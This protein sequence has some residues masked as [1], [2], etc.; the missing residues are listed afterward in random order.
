M[1]RR[2]AFTIIALAAAFIVTFNLISGG[3]ALRSS[4]PA[5]PDV[6]I[7]LDGLREDDYVLLATDPTDLAGPIAAWYGTT[8]TELTKLYAAN[9]GNYLYLYVDLPTYSKGGSSGEIGVAIDTSGDVSNSGGSA[10]PWLNEI[11]FAYTSTQ[12]QVGGTPV[13]STNTILPDFMIRGN[14][15]GLSGNPPDDNNGWTEL[16]TWSSAGAGGWSGA[17]TNWGGIPT[18]GQIGTY[19]AYSDNRGVEFK[20]P[21]AAL[22]L[23]PGESV[24]LEFFTTQ[25]GSASVKGAFDTL[26]SDDQSTG[27]DDA[28]VQKRLATYVI[29]GASPTETPTATNTPQNTLTPTPGPLLT[30]TPTATPNGVGPCAGTTAGDGNITTAEVYHNSTN[31]TYREPQGSITITGTATLRLRT[32]QNDVQQVK[33][34]VWKT[35]DP[36]GSPSNIYNAVVAGYDPSGPYEYW[37]YDVPGPGTTVDQWYQ[38][39]ITDGA[40]T[41]YY[42][43]LQGASNT[44]PGAW[45]ESLLD[46]SWKLG[47]QPAPTQDYAVPS[48]LKDAIIYQIFPDRFRD[49]NSANNAPPYT[50]NVTI[51]GP[52]TCAGYPH[53]HNSDPDCVVDGRAWNDSLL[54]PSWGLDF[55]GGDLQGVIDKINSGY[56]TDLGINTIY[57]NPVFNASSNHGYDANDYYNIRPYFGDNALFDTLIAAAD[58]KGIRVILD[59]VVNHAG[60]DSVYMEGYG[61]NRWPATSGACES[62]SSPFRSWFNAG[63]TGVGVCDGGWGWRGWWGF[64]T[65]PEFLEIDPV[66]DFFYRGGSA[67]S[68]SGVSVTQFWQNKGIGGW[69]Y[70]VA[71]DVSLAWF[72]DMRKYVKGVSGG[73]GDTEM[74]MLGEVTGG[75]DWGLYKNYLTKDGL[76]TVMNYCFRDW[77]V[78][79]ANGGNPSSFDGQ[80]NNFRT[81]MP[82]SP[83]FGMMNLVDSHDS[84]RVLRLLN[85]DKDKLKLL[86]ILQMTLPGAPSVYYGD[87]VGITGGGDPDN[88][89]TYPWADTGGSPDTNLYTHY[90]TLINL[91]RDYSA[92]RGGDVR[93]LLIDDTKHLYSYARWDNN[94]TFVVVLNNGVGAQSTSVPVAGTIP[95]GAVLTDLLNGGTYTVVGGYIDIASVAGRWGRI[96]RVTSWPTADFEVYAPMVVCDR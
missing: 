26:P 32:C 91:R 35:G 43:V 57:F 79:F 45:S 78:S 17:G 24:N 39:R 41:G 28:T 47:T 22:G 56:F 88:R 42:H 60:S 15:P 52:N 72:A 5:L 10:D 36:L 68:P 40:H 3:F 50:A 34:M 70:D 30:A 51:Y 66:K 48:W 7:T 76:D 11:T 16:R 44:G 4:R 86:V 71:Q 96:L 62:S 74:L 33:V 82:R 18:G 89:R 29:S 77:A 84:T 61:G 93:T 13:T 14:I 67:Q 23:A 1:L 20:I 46:L 37:A 80:Y 63:S 81:L 25:K 64:E 87:E 83:W 59:L 19:I 65:I 55:Y 12:N 27:W 90:K 73:Y 94:D 21:L 69:R 92:L 54:I 6:S 38:F 85:D 9:D 58:A 49:G 95:N 75:C 31:L 53:G 8:W 2:S